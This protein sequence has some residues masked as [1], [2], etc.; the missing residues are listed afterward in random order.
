MDALV[1]T[2]IGTR[3]CDIVKIYNNLQMDSD[4]RAETETE[5]FRHYVASPNPCLP[6]AYDYMS[7][8]PVL[9]ADGCRHAS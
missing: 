8:D 6:V 9:N 4:Q 7:N 5:F 3:W 1:M 2:A